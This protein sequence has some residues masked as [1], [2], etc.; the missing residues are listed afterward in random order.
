MLCMNMKQAVSREV[1]AAPCITAKPEC[2]Y[3]SLAL[4][5]VTRHAM[6]PSSFFPDKNRQ[7]YVCYLYFDHSRVSTRGDDNE[8]PPD[9][10]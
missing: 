10:I 8:G 9:L 6:R 5:V 1:A 4:E 7:S 3:L 2:S